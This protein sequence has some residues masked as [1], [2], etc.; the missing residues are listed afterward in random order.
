MRDLVVNGY[1]ESW[2]RKGF[3]W[4]YPKEL[5]RG[6]AKVGEQIRLVSAQGKPLGRGLAD[7]GFLAAR[8]MRHDSGPLDRDWLWGV[9]DRA[10]ALRERVIDSGTTAYRLVH[11]ES[12][13][14]PG[15]RVDWW[16]HYATV[17]LDSPALEP[18]VEEVCA[19]LVERRSPRGVYTCYRPDPRDPRDASSWRGRLLHGHAP[20]ADV[21]VTERGLA[22]LVRPWDG[23][24]V[25]LYP[26]MREVRAWLEPHW[27]GRTVLNTFAYTGF[28]SVAAAMN[29]AAEV[30]TTDLSE[31]H[32][33]RAEAN[34]EANELDPS[35]HRFLAGDTF[36]V[37]DRLR[38]SGERFDL[39]LLDPPAF[40][41]SKDG[42][43]SGKKDYPRLV[44]AA[45][46]VLEPDGWLVA[47]SNQ[48]E[49]SPREFRGAVATG[50]KKAGARGQELL[51]AQ[52]AADHPAGTWFPE[53]RRLK[54]GV[55]RV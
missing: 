31:P 24:D 29:G 42:V 16:D 53:A 6:R 11:G 43:W 27:G 48:G 9:L 38:R 19:W 39:V 26:D 36:K 4:V 12:D 2:L 15:I 51:W 55:W 40:S 35:L 28:F 33:D 46:R 18:L 17:V 23:P 30:V 14:L 47:A 32:L 20:T 49:V 7:Q 22:A 5:T 25:G 21:R 34:F 50:L 1:S 44:S 13:D 52:E 8:V 41:H 3:P 54:V 45:A 10:A 37:L